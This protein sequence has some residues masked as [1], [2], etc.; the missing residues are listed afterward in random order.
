MSKTEISANDTKDAE[1][2]STITV[3]QLPILFS[4]P[5][6]P[7]GYKPLLNCEWVVKSNTSVLRPTVH[8]LT[9][10]L[11]DQF[12]CFADYLEV[13]TSKDMVKWNQAFK[14]CKLEPNQAR[15][16]AGDPYLKVTFNSD[17]FGNKTGISGVFIGKCGGEFTDASGVIDSSMFMET[18]TENECKWKIHVQRGRKIKFRFTR[19]A[20]P[21]NAQGGCVSYVMLSNGEDEESPI[22]GVGKYCGTEIPDVPLTTSNRAF[23]KFKNAYPSGSWKLSYETVMNECEHNIILSET[24]NSTSISTENFPHIPTPHSVCTWTILAPLGEHIQVHFHNFNPAQDLNCQN[25]YFEILDGATA[26]S[27]QLLV[28]CTQPNSIDST[29]NAMRIKYFSDTTD[30]SLTFNATVSIGKCGGTYHDRSGTITSKNYPHLGQYPS[31]SICEYRILLPVGAIINITF[32]DINL[33]AGDCKTVDNLEVSYIAQGIENSTETTKYNF[34]GGYTLPYLVINDNEALLRFQTFKPNTVYRGF[35][36]SYTS[37]LHGC[38]GFINAEQGIIM[39]PGYP[40]GWGNTAVCIWKIT[41]PKGRRIKMEFL[42]YDVPTSHQG[43]AVFRPMQRRASR[44]GLFN[45][46]RYL[47]GIGYYYTSPPSVVYSSDNQM[48]VS[49]WLLPAPGFRGIKMRYSSNERTICEGSLKDTFGL[50]ALPAV[51]TSLICSYEVQTNGTETIAFTFNDFRVDRRM[52]R[53]PCELRPPISILDETGTKMRLCQN[54]TETTLRSPF[55]TTKLQ[56]L[57]LLQTKIISFNMTYKRHNC[58]G[59]VSLND[60]YKIISPLVTVNSSTSY[61]TLDCAWLVAKSTKDALLFK[62]SGFVKLKLGCDKEYL[63][64]K[65]S[66]TG[67]HLG[68]ICGD[69]TITNMSTLSQAFIEYHADTFSADTVVNITIEDIDE[70]GDH[71]FNAPH[72]I[73]LKDDYKSNVECIWTIKSNSG[74]HLQ[75][76][77]IDRFY[78][79]DSA[80]CSK[81]VLKIYDYVDGDWVLLDGVCGRTRPPVFNSTENVLRLKF[82]SDESVEGDGFTMRFGNKCGGVYF[83]QSNKHIITSPNYPEK[84]NDNLECNYTLVAPSPEDVILVQ[85]TDF[86]IEN[87]GKCQYDNVTIYAYNYNSYEKLGTYCTDS[88]IS[89]LRH[90]DRISIVFKTDANGQRKGF[91]FEYSLDRCGGVVSHSKLISSP[92]DNGSGAG[93]MYPPNAHCVWNITAPKDKE[94][95]I[96]FEH[97]EVEVSSRCYYDYVAI[98]K[99]SKELESNKVATLCGNLTGKLPTVN[100]NTNHAIIHFH[101]DPSN[102]DRG[103]SAW[104]LFKDQCDRTITLDANSPSY[105]FDQFY[106]SMYQ[107]NL[108]CNYVFSAPDGY[109]IQVDFDQFHVAPCTGNQTDTC[110]C[111]YLELRDGAGPFS[112]LIGRFCGHG[113]PPA[114]ISTRTK[115][116]LKFVS[117]SATTS[118]GIKATFKLVASRC[119][120]TNHILEDAQVI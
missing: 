111:D 64:I 59:I 20:L 92:K 113:L 112:E 45:D 84:Y 37:S 39:T 31:N 94:I 23:V 66:P 71:V 4:S 2:R 82:K 30:P 110:S 55:L 29:A 72:T 13:F 69:M 49:C 38:G 47:S 68:R 14:G 7:N 115:M 83:V 21:K 85:F 11:D 114:A 1:C 116:F 34:C 36:L 15:Q 57:Q 27:K 101:T 32:I 58:G 53:L 99:G 108:D 44:I 41:V 79:E 33:P 5:G 120:P 97:L 102:S 88:S 78:I 18:N 25:E 73:R 62:I 16:I 77:F 67:P 43:F 63:S 9:V 91:R 48:L 26:L 54:T 107:T 35:K 51:N 76:E 86:E 93:R 81:D 106:G 8:L 96:K 3:G 24:L 10:D 28:N 61:G 56:V 103:F 42:D 87:I 80:N 22:L 52:M 98:F 89:E 95:I 70:C 46:H 40:N 6:F 105:I 17:A 104:V 118:N 75:A 12:G 119:G 109:H 100:I 19:M 60:P 74:Y 117:D 50:I 65:Q 90:K